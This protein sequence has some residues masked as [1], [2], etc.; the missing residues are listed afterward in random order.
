MATAADDMVVNGGE[1]G[2]VKT[3]KEPKPSATSTGSGS[4]TSGK[5]E[6]VL[7]LPNGREESRILFPGD[8]IIKVCGLWLKL[9]CV[10]KIAWVTVNN[11]AI[12]HYLILGS[13]GG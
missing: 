12:V 9:E 8:I 2:E 7:Y 11:V 1:S 3:V 13:V 4:K 5:P 6:A 10:C